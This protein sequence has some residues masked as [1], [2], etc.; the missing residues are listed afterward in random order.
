MVLWLKSLSI[1]PDWCPLN[2]KG[3]SYKAFDEIDGME[4]AWNQVKLTDVLRTPDDLERLY[5]EVHL[6]RTL[7]NKNIMKFYTSCVDTEKQNIN[8]IT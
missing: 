5:C 2:L 1:A 4:V 3:C 8:F 7:K 6:L